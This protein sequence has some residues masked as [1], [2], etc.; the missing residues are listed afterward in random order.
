MKKTVITTIVSSLFMLSL[1]VNLQSKNNAALEKAFA[2][3]SC[4]PELGS[5][6]I[7]EDVIIWDT[8]LSPRDNCFPLDPIIK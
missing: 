5:V 7:F 4:C 2:A 3:G 6:C 1:F 8:Y